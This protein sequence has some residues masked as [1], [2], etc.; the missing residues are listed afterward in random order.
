MPFE[1][2]PAVFAGMIAGLFME[3]PMAMK[4]AGVPM[5]MDMLLTWG[6][7]MKVHGNAGRALGMGIHL[8]LSAAVALI[9]ALGFNV[10]NATGA[11]WAW[12]LLG[13]L[14]HWAIAGMVLSMIPAMHPEMPERVP[15]PGAYV[16]SF[17]PLD[18]GGFLMGHLLYGLAVGV[19]YA[20]FHSAGGVEAAF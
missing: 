2:W 11:F 7:M 15:A 4:L 19:F 20:L 5:K 8:M 1:F 14:I 18:M 3:M 13:G 16:R 17:G 6:T 12:G 10:L 9:Y